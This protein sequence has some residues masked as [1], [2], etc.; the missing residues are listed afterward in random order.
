MML[1]NLAPNDGCGDAASFTDSKT[2]IKRNDR[3]ATEFDRCFSAAMNQEMHEAFRSSLMAGDNQAD[4]QLSDE[5]QI[6]ISASNAERIHEKT[7]EHRGKPSPP[8]DQPR[9]E[10]S[11]KCRRTKRTASGSETPLPKINFD[12]I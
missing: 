3:D 7:P 6:S 8:S 4:A 10:W 5:K 11:P 1:Q 12:A 2:N 9:F